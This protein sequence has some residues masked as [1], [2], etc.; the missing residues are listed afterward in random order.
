MAGKTFHIFSTLS[1][2]VAYQEWVPGGADIPV[3]GRKVLIRGGT[4]IA[5]KHLITPMGVHTEIDEDELRILQNDEVFKLH[6]KNGF[7]TIEEKYADPEKVA[8]DMKTNDKSSPLTE[9]DKAELEG[10]GKGGNPEAPTGRNK[11]EK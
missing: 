10:L 11:K 4:G 1:A 9:A 5:H 3:P 7:V 6:K 8:A 2:N